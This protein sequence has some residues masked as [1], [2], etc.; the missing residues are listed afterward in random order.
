MLEISPGCL[1]AA[2]FQSTLSIYVGN[3]SLLLLLMTYLGP[4][5][6]LGVGPQFP[7]YFS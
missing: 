4:Q 7:T 3:L 2:I 6:L 5:H 1:L